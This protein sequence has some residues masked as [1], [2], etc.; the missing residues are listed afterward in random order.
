MKMKKRTLAALLILVMVLSLMPLSALAVSD[1]DNGDWSAKAVALRNTAEAELMVRTGDIDAL[2]EEYAI[3]DG[4]NPFTASNQRAHGYPWE[5]DDTDPEGTD[6]IF[7]GSHWNGD[8]R[9]G[10]SS[11]YS[12][13]KDDPEDE[14]NASLAFGEGAAVITLNYD[15]PGITVKNA[16]LQICIDDFQALSWESRFTVTLNGKDTPFIAE[17]LNHAD[18]TGPTSYIISAILP[19]S[20]HEDVASGKLA[21]SIDEETGC[22]DGFAVDFVKLLVNYQK[23]VFTGKFSGFT[24]PGA[25]VRLLGTSTTVTASD[26]GGF[27]FEAIPGLNA[28]RASKTGYVEG[29]NY[30]IVVSDKAEAEEWELWTPYL[31]LYEGQGSPDIDFTQFGTTAAWENAHNWAKPELEEAD[32][33]GLI[34]DCLKGADL[35]QPI[36]RAEFAAVSVKL[37]EAMSFTKA[38]PA[39]ADTFSD[40]SDPEVLKAFALGVTNGTDAVK[41][42]FEPDT[43]ISREQASTMLTRVWKKLN[44]SGWTLE[45]DGSFADEFR[46]KFTM[47]ALFADDAEISPWARDSVYFMAANRIVNGVGDNR[48]APKTVSSGEET[49][50]FAT[51]EQALLMSVRTVKNLG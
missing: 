37:F 46:T 22:G 12:S 10:Y 11:N 33:L 24:E 21:V 36:T 47:P 2:N 8:A 32:K 29:Y 9:D 4:Y 7:V 15:A 35:T 26:S 23:D 18:Q 43:L 38:S 6:R 30:G 16:L 20:F 28:I 44:L 51:R 45:T 41:K 19:P 14:W 31:N 17:L 13:W 3:D 40:T 25:T 34:P 39:P 50:N 5:K 27:T 1:A 42:T 49:L 48:F